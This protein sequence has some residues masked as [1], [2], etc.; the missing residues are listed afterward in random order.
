MPTQVRTLL[1]LE[2]LVAFTLSV[3][4]YRQWSPHGW[5]LFLAL[6]LVPDLS[7]L[8]YL[9]GSTFGALSYNLAHTYLIPGALIGLAA[10]WG[11]PAVLGIALIWS[12]HIGFDRLL[13]YG[14][15]LPSGFHF[16][17]LGAIGRANPPAADT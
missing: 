7:L 13:G 12:A 5:A 15:K 8:G 4:A 14:L 16:T 17:H 3:M 2:G 11:G 10:L 6:F 1:R 9:H